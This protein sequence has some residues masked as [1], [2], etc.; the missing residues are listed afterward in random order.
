M[1]FGDSDSFA[2]FP[3]WIRIWIPFFPFV[4]WLLWQG[5][6]KLYVVIEERVDIL[7]LFLILEEIKFLTIEYNVCCEFVIYG[8]YYV[9]VGSLSTG[10]Q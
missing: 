5:L 8:L 2:S 3:I 7:V 1:S 10:K 9:E 6:S 4:L